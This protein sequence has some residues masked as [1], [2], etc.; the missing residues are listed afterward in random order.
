VM[1]A[2]RAN[3]SHQIEV[4]TGVL[5]KQSSALLSRFFA[6]TRASKKV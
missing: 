4:R 6:E 2:T 3:W 5:E 1:D